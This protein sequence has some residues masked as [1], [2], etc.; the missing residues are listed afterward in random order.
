MKRGERV[1]KVFVRAYTNFNLGDDLFIKIL[2][3]RYPD[4]KFMLYAPKKYKKIFNENKNVKVYSKENIFYRGFNFINRLFKSNYTIQRFLEK[5]ADAIVRI[6]GSIF[7]QNDNWIKNLKNNQNSF[8]KPYYVLGANFGPYTDEEYYSSYKKIFKSYTDVCFRDRYSYDLFSELN[9]VRV[10]DDI[11]FQMETKPEKIDNSIVISVIK[12]SYRE[13][14][15]GYDDIYYIKL[16]EIIIKYVNNG[17]KITL[18]SFCENEEDNIAIEELKKM[19]PKK[20]KSQV[21]T[22]IY[23]T[24]INKTLKIIAKSKYIIAT[25]FHAMILGWIYDKPIYP[26]TY[27]RKMINV[28]QDI[29]FNFGYADFNNLHNLNSEEVF[30]NLNENNKVNIVKARE[31]A[32][33][34]FEKLDEYLK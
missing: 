27:S 25:R 2:V 21:R 34:H 19:L 32:E 24:N 26:I 28:I 18:M 23:K 7:M 17:Y 12:P 9:N 31:T 11:V 30:N 14:L 6:G 33:K 8:H 3:E 5:Q 20:Y 10:A 4:I 15:Q 1:Q 16:K 29:G 13:Y 22:H